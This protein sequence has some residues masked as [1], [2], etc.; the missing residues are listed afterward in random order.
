MLGICVLNSLVILYSGLLFSDDL[1]ND[2][3]D[4]GT[5]SGNLKTTI[6]GQVRN[7][8][9]FPGAVAAHAKAE[10]RSDKPTRRISL[11]TFPVSSSL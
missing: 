6:L 2:L 8:I 1:K 5:I 7:P 9:L 4:V 3:W 11:Q 10:H